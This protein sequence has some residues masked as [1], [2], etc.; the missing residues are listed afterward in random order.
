MPTPAKSHDLSRITLLI[1]GFVINGFGEGGAVTVEPLSSSRESSV[2]QDGQATYATS[3]DFRAKVT[4]TVRQNSRA[5]QD[6][7]ALHTAQLAAPVLLPLSFSLINLNT[8]ERVN[9]NQAVFLDRPSI[10][11]Q[12]APQDR[13]YVLELP[14]GYAPGNYSGAPLIVL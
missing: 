8:G 10:A 3:N 13:V 6:L 9:D 14:N 2:G 12:R 7:H 11:F 4:I 1:G 5:H